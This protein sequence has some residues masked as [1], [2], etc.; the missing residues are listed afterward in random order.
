MRTQIETQRHVHLHHEWGELK[1]NGHELGKTID[2]R[3]RTLHCRAEVCVSR[4]CRKV[5]PNR[6]RGQSYILGLGLEC[7]HL[8]L[9]SEVEVLRIDEFQLPVLSRAS[10][11][12]NASQAIGEIGL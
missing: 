10:G 2:M 7:A 5:P 4:H 1:G 9:L 3:T 11:D 6:H 8:H 12:L